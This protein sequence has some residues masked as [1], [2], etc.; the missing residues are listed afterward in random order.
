MEKLPSL[1]ISEEEVIIT[2]KKY[3]VSK[4]NRKYVFKFIQ[5]AM[6]ILPIQYPEWETHMDAE[7][8]VEVDYLVR[9]CK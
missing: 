9:L 1:S 5:Q 8:F 4:R 2:M 3:K 6:K 7:L